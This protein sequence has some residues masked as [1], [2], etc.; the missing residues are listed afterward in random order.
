MTLQAGCGGLEGSSSARALHVGNFPW[1]MR[2]SGFT[3]R[4]LARFGR[5]WPHQDFPGG[6]NG[7][8]TGAYAPCDELRGWSRALLQLSAL[9]PHGDL[10]QG[11]SS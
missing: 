2:Y 10:W 11:G 9:H 8:P 4:S 6:D 7:L 5:C 3:R 1:C